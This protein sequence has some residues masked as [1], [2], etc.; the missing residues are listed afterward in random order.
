M[1]KIVIFFLIIISSLFIAINYKN[2]NSKKKDLIVQETI[3]ETYTSNIIN[4]VNYE[5][6]D[7]NGNKYVIDAE[8]GEID[9]SN[10][11]IIFLTNVKAIIKMNNSENVTITSDFGKYNINNYDTIFSKN[12]IIKYLDNKITGNYADFSIVRNSMIISKK[13]VYSNSENILEADTI[14]MNLETKDTKIYMYEKK[15]KVKVKSKN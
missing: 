6:M 5:S 10:N 14:N 7:S 11:N 4:G 2:S 8:K 3:K 12:V 15:R 9:L 13:V 1:K